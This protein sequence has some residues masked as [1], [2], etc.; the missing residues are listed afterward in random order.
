MGS[1]DLSE[2]VIA[3]NAQERITA[4]PPLAGWR[5]KIPCEQIER[6]RTMNDGPNRRNNNVSCTN[7]E[8]DF[9]PSLQLKTYCL[10][11]N[12]AIVLFARNILSYI[13]MYFNLSSNIQIVFFI[14]D[15]FIKICSLCLNPFSEC[16]YNQVLKNF[17]CRCKDGYE[18][19]GSSCAKT[20]GT[21]IFD[22]IW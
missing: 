4:C 6:G 1:T 18:G 2:F 16:V 15:E 20:L 5:V 21:F 17:E 13:F 3:I 9:R 19:D 12:K 14:L 10:D 8:D 11:G 7:D 22:L